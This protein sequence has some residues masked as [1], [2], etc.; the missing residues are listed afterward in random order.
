MYDMRT[1]CHGTHALRL[2]LVDSSSQDAS[3]TSRHRLAFG[4]VKADQEERDIVLPWYPPK[5]GKVDLSGEVSVSI[6]LVRDLEFLEIGLVVHVPAKDD[7]AEAEARRSN[8]KE[9]L[10]GDQL[11]S[12]DTVN[13]AS[14]QLDARVI[15][16]KLWQI[17]EHKSRRIVCDGHVGIGYCRADGSRV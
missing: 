3:R 2:N 11:A 6:L 15:L 1:S 8:R 7:R 12:Q 13:V 16:Q 5:T 9:L 17:F 4:L 14:C 10:F